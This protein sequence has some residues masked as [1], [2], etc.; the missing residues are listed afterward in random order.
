ML[1]QLYSHPYQTLFEFSRRKLEHGSE[2]SCLFSKGTVAAAATALFGSRSAF[3]PSVLRI[4]H[5][6]LFFIIDKKDMTI[7]FQGTVLRL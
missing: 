7:F 5:P 2:L 1:S 4:D 3:G 6:F